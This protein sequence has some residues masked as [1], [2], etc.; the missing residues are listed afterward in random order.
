MSIDGV[1]SGRDT[2]D[3][4]GGAERA[5]QVA[6]QQPGSAESRRAETLSREEYSDQVRA[7]G[8]PIGQRETSQ[9]GAAD[10]GQ[11][12]S[13][14]SGPEDRPSDHVDDESGDPGGD[15]GGLDSS[16]E[17]DEPAGDGPF[18][19]SGRAKPGDSEPASEVA[20]RVDSSPGEADE[21]QQH[22]PAADR[23]G[24]SPDTKWEDAWTLPDG[25]QVRVHMDGDRDWMHTGAGDD[26]REPPTG[27]ELLSMEND[28]A[29]RPEKLRSKFFEQENVENFLDAEK[30]G[31]KVVQDVLSPP[32]HVS[33][34]TL[35][36]MVEIAPVQPPQA[37]AGD[38]LTGITV[39]ALLSAEAI[40]S[41][42][43]HWRAMERT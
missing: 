39:F 10:E 13:R 18:A 15:R 28:E 36:P 4:V 27:A 12:E 42:A 25:R 23:A 38:A 30:E 41:A 16:S 35:T 31:A 33:A 6:G 29:S 20:E 32:Q 37:D 24:T 40:R 34:H 5:E 14:A 11:R 19:D 2:D 7:R 8:S 9:D 26:M 22:D 3:S 21:F 1:S 17:R 43:R